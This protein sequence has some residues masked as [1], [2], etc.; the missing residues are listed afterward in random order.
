M[1]ITLEVNCT[2]G[3]KTGWGWGNDTYVVIKSLFA[4]SVT[5]YNQYSKHSVR[6]LSL[7]VTLARWAT[8]K[9]WNHNSFLMPIYTAFFT[10][11]FACHRCLCFSVALTL[12]FSVW[13]GWGS[14]ASLSLGIQSW[15]LVLFSGLWVFI[16]SYQLGISFVSWYVRGWHFNSSCEHS[17]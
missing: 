5:S 7:N 8:R 4:V 9:R 14:Y 16:S 15:L 10:L 12:C 1:S 17:F 3:L 11:A 2:M 13:S 6:Q